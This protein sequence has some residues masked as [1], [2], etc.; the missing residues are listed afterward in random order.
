MSEYPRPIETPD[1]I[2]K[3]AENVGGTITGCAALPDGSGFATM[4]MPLSKTH[5]IYQKGTD[6]FS[7]PPP[8]PFRVGVGQQIDVAMTREEFSRRIWDAAKY[9]VR[10]ATMHGAEMDFD[11]DALCQNMVVGMLGYWTA[12]GLSG[13]AWAN[14]RVPYEPPAVDAVDPHATST[15]NPPTR[16]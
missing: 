7:Q 3:L 8:M 14:P 11:P 9:A 15:G 12:D 13:D 5:W 16:E 6:G 10:G 1:V 2:A 4:S